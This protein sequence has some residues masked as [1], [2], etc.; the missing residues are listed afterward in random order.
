MDIKDVESRS[1]FTFSDDERTSAYEQI[2]RYL[3]C[4]LRLKDLSASD[5][6]PMI[7]VLEIAN[8]YRND[9]T[10][11]KTVNFNIEINAPELFDGYYVVPKSFD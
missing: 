8:I 4:F 11:R 1:K 3:N 5:A 2:R 6:E 7:N 10:D 9:E